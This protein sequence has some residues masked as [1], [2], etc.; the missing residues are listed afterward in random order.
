MEAALPSNLCGQTRHPRTHP[1]HV[2][3]PALKD[4]VMA[5]STR[6]AR[7]ALDPQRCPRYPSK[8]DI[9]V[10][11]GRML[12]ADLLQNSAYDGAGGGTGG[13]FLS[14][15]CT[16]WIAG[17][18]RRDFTDACNATQRTRGR[19]VVAG[20]PTWQ[21]LAEVCAN[22]CQ[23]ELELGTTLA[24]AIA[25]GR[26]GRRRFKCAKALDTFLSRVLLETP[27]VLVSARATRE[28]PRRYCA[29]FCGRTFGQH[30]T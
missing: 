5:C 21:A 6:P 16:R 10:A 20:R 13:A 29:G 14:H 18:L 26:A 28:L 23:R 4:R 24:R 19:T 25:N 15:P 7:V 2:A 11:F 30:V 17:D 3:P 9:G 1:L 22:R 8:A 12:C 27:P